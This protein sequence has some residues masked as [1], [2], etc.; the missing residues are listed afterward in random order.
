L[1]SVFLSIFI[2]LCFLLSSFI[3]IADFS[4]LFYVVSAFFI[5]FLWPLL[6]FLD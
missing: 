3:C 6:H 5:S 1:V 2:L 4:T